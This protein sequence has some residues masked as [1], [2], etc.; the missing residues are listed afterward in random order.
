MDKLEID[1][2]GK[3]I[4]VKEKVIINKLPKEHWVHRNVKGVNRYDSCL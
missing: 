1:I 3:F 2:K 4:L